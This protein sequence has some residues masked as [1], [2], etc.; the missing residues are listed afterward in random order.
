MIKS[1]IVVKVRTFCVQV[2]RLG[3]VQPFYYKKQDLSRNFL[4]QLFRDVEVGKSTLN[5]IVIFEAF[6]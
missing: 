1:A 4:H 3:M 2:K 5:I 6:H